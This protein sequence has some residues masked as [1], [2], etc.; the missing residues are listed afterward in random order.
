MRPVNDV[1]KDSGGGSSPVPPDYV[2]PEPTFMQKYGKFVFWGVIAV[3]ALAVIA[4][5]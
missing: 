5:L 2:V 3:V 1:E 4:S